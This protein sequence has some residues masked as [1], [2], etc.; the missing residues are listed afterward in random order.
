MN[1]SNIAHKESLR[2]PAS[3]NKY[4]RPST[5]YKSPSKKALE[6]SVLNGSVLNYTNE[7][8]EIVGHGF[9]YPAINIIKE[10]NGKD[11]A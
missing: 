2:G 3:P 1:T 6:G 8:G 11:A 10:L 7:A 9:S 5:G 4:W